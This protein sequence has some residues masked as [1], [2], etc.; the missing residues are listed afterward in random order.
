M[1]GEYIITFK[2][3]KDMEEYKQIKGYEEL[4]W[5]SNTGIVKSIR[6]NS[7]KYSINGENKSGYKNV[8]L[9]K[10]GIVKKYTIHQLVA[11]NFI[12]ERP[13]GYIIN[14]I[15]GNKLN[16]NHFNLE[17]I[18][19]SQNHIHAIKIGLR[20]TGGD[21]SFSRKIVQMDMNAIDIKTFNSIIEAGKELGISR[22]NI[23]S[24]C[25]GVIKSYK[26]FRFRF[27]ENEYIIP[28]SKCL[29][30]KEFILTRN[31]KKWCNI[32]CKGKFRNN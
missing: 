17:Y 11:Q 14:H 10:N 15:D 19:H 30:G 7:L 9:S 18:T 1:E 28:K 4:Y 6:K 2:N 20:K 31:N 26:G 29:C 5:I 24:C 13:K 23:G 16:N 3:K 25:R 12:G 8:S 27:I 21:L 22:H 32:K